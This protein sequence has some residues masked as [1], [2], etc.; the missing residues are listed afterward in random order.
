MYSLKLKLSK[1]SIFFLLF[2]RLVS[3]LFFEFRTKTFFSFILLMA[4]SCNLS[5]G[6]GDD[7]KESSSETEQNSGEDFESSPEVGTLAVGGVPSLDEIAELSS[8]SATEAEVGLSGIS[9]AQG[10]LSIDLSADRSSLQL[11]QGECEGSFFC[12]AKAFTDIYDMI[13]GAAQCNFDLMLAGGQK[14]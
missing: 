2:S 5:G 11:S 12:F 4:T 1:T 6:G 13:T 14:P 3:Q 10:S 7:K 9:A 8:L